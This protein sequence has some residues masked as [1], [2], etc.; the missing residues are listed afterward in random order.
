MKKLV[1][2]VALVLAASFTVQAAEKKEKAKGKR[3]ELSAEQKALYQE[4]T[5]KYDTDG[6][7]GLSGDEKAK[8]S[9]EDKKKAADAK[10]PGFGPAKKKK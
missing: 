2:I 7:K 8:M 4:L 9:D 6:K 1:Y 3:P 5:K 10:L